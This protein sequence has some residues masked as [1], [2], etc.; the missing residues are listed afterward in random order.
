MG[1]MNDE[2]EA[3]TITELKRKTQEWA[4][5]ARESGMEV[6]LGWNRER[7]VKTVEGFRITLHA[8]T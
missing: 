6:H 4:R 2:L 7:V 3:T 5:H 1:G 8:H